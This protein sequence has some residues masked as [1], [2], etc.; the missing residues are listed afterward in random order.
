MRWCDGSIVRT[1]LLVFIGV[2]L[3]LVLILKLLG[4]LMGFEIEFHG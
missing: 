2:P 1:W 3:V 4:F